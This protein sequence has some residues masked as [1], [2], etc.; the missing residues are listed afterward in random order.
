MELPGMPEAAPVLEAARTLARLKV[1]RDELMAQRA[2]ETDA[3]FWQLYDAELA[4]ADAHLASCNWRLEEELLL[5]TDQAGSDHGNADWPSGDAEVG[6]HGRDVVLELAPGV[7]GLEA[8]LFAGEMFQM[9]E[10][11]AGSRGWQWEVEHFVE[12]VSNSLQNATVKVSS[13]EGP[14]GWL[15]SESGVHR[16]QRIPTTDRKGRM[17][18]SSTTV[19]VLP[20]AAEEDLALAPGDLHVEISKKSSGPGGQSVNAAHQAIRMTHLPTGLSVHSTSSPSQFENR[21]RALEMLRTKLLSQHMAVR[22]RFEQR[23]R[24]EQ[25]GTGDRSEKIRTYNFQRDS[26]MD[27]VLGKVEGGLPSANEVLFGEGLESVL[28]A[29]LDRSRADRLARA[30]DLL[31]AQLQSLA[32]PTLKC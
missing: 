19:V 7:G 24:K 30:L 29:H 26:V 1:E 22:S 2:R 31:Q 6:N 25:R 10:R 4:T 14:F 17:Q 8:A 28:R 27:H 9:Y 32:R 21:K 13:A 15:C 20:V 16:V 12:G 23:E 5:L 3:E 11:F 18:T